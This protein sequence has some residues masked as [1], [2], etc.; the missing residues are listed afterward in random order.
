[1]LALL[2]REPC[3]LF[4]DGLLFNEPSPEVI[5]PE[6]GKPNA[7][8]LVAELVEIPELGSVTPLFFDSPA[9]MMVVD[10]SDILADA[11]GDTPNLKGG[12]P[13]TLGV[14][15]APKLT[16]LEGSEVTVPLPHGMTSETLTAGVKITGG[17]VEI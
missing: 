16:L 10:A 17:E 15:D 2:N 7:T 4:S 6:P 12:S 13:E 11:S 5:F 3:E 8:K 14:S 9:G 1:M